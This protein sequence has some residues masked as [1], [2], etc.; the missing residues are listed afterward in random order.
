MNIKLLFDSS[1]GPCRLRG[2]GGE[3][4]VLEADYNSCVEGI[5]N[6]LNALLCHITTA[7][8]PRRYRVTLSLKMIKD[9]KPF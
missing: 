5:H 4:P 2:E 6:A 8:I 1:A 3:V 9:L 7:D